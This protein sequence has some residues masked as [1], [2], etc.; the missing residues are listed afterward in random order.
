MCCSLYYYFFLKQ[1][2]SLIS[3]E[4]KMLYQAR[5]GVF[6]CEDGLYSLRVPYYTRSQIFIFISGSSGAASHDELA[7]KALQISR[8]QRI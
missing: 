4:V 5:G 8:K 1:N 7:K 2:T 3:H 6:V